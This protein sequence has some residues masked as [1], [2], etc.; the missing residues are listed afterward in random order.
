[1]SEHKW[2]T[3]EEI[4]CIRKWSLVDAGETDAINDLACVL[5]DLDAAKA[6][7]RKA[8][9]YVPLLA[10]VAMFKYAKPAMLTLNGDIRAVPGVAEG[11]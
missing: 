5:D 8:L 10:D 9:P 7:L 3:E 2:L 1:M 6:L 11:E 4:E